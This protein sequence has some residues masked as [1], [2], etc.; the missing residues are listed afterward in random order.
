[1]ISSFTRSALVSV[2]AAAAETV[3]KPY[4]MKSMEMDELAAV[5]TR[6]TSGHRVGQAEAKEAEAA[7]DQLSRCPTL[8]V[9]SSE[10][11]LGAGSGAAEKSVTMFKRNTYK[12]L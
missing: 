4:M 7:I 11:A 1:M 12:L 3:T 10:V 2:V 6:S 5:P 8:A 9:V